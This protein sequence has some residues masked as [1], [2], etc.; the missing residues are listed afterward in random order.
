MGGSLERV[1]RSF[2]DS[3]LQLDALGQFFG[4]MQFGTATQVA[5]GSIEGLLFG[6]CVAGALVLARRALVPG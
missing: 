5:L 2:G 1:A 6:S 3:Q 4:E